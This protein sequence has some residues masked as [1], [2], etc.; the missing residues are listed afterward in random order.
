MKEKNDN[1]RS[2]PKSNNSLNCNTH[3][4]TRN[5]CFHY[6]SHIPDMSN[7]RSCPRQHLATTHKLGSPWYDLRGWLGVKLQLSIYLSPYSSFN[8]TLLPPYTPTHTLDQRNGR[9]CHHLDNMLLPATVI[10]F[11]LSPCFLRTPKLTLWIKEMDVCA[12]T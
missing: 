12:N 6:I 3:N 9:L 8:V 4:L 11:V 1:S 2:N 5:L 10:F 7:V